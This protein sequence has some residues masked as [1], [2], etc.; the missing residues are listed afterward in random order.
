MTNLVIGIDPG[1]ITGVC[2]LEFSPARPKGE[3]FLIAQGNKLFELV[4]FVGA[5]IEL[6]K[7]EDGN[8]FFLITEDQ[9]IA[10]LPLFLGPQGYA[11]RKKAECALVC[12]QSVGMWNLFA[13]Q[14]G[15]EIM[16]PVKPEVWRK[17]IYGKGNLRTDAAKDAALAYVKTVYGKE[18]KAA[19]HHSAE[20]CA[21]ATYGMDVIKM[22]GVL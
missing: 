4:E 5:A 15:I 8:K 3:I 9:F 2:I 6:L 10:P 21:I 20:A 1:A 16:E 7:K 22:G 14:N 19:R 13:H 11:Y 17:A 12:C 18:L